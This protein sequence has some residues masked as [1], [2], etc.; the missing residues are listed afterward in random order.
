MKTK[1]RSEDEAF[2]EK[3][4][5]FIKATWPF[6]SDEEVRDVVAGASRYGNRLF[7]K[8]APTIK[9]MAS[10]AAAYPFEELLRQQRGKLV[11]TRDLKIGDIVY[12][13]GKNKQFAIVSLDERD[14]RLA[15]KRRI[16][17]K[18]KKTKK[19]S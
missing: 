4:F 17:A 18:P 7:R 6:L 12:L 14:A 10:R 8:Y 19:I 5:G 13:D 16:E 15:V 9:R 1:K 11:K 2:A 3:L